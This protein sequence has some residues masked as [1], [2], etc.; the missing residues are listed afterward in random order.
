MPICKSTDA[1]TSAP[2]FALSQ[3]KVSTTQ[4]NMNVAYG[5]TTT[6]AFTTNQKVGVFG[7]DATEQ[8]VTA[9]PHGGHAGWVLRT[10]GTGGRAGR[11]HIETL[12]AMGSMTGDGGAAGANDDVQFADA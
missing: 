3:L 10:E 5:N 6:G 9:N 1:N 11:V 2:L 8:G 12:V 4:A 7:V